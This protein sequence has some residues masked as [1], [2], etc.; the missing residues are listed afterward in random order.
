MSSGERPIGAAKGKQ[1]D[2]EALFQPPPP[3]FALCGARKHGVGVLAVL[4]APCVSSTCGT[5]ATFCDAKALFC[6]Q[7]ISCA[8]VDVKWVIMLLREIAKS[9]VQMDTVI[10]VS[11][12]LSKRVQSPFQCFRAMQHPHVLPHALSTKHGAL[13]GGWE[14]RGLLGGSIRDRG[15]VP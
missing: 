13:G 14:T 7:V 2:T 15:F 10:E 3:R 5:R 12:I 4:E 6:H 1:S 8:G 11:P 9:K